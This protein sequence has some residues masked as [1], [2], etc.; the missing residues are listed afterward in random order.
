MSFED[1]MSS[2]IMINSNNMLSKDEKKKEKVLRRFLGTSNTV[3][4]NRIYK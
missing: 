3:M 2:E 1:P 4:K